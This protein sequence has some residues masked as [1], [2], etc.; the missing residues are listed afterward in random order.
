VSGLHWT[1]PNGTS[2]PGKVFPPP[3]VHV[4]VSTRVA[5]FVTGC[6]TGA[7]FVAPEGSLFL[8]TLPGQLTGFPFE[9]LVQTAGPP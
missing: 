6:V 4:R 2:A 8:G 7:V 5:G 3:V 1:I 9:P